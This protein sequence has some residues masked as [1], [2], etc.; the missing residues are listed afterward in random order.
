MLYTVALFRNFVLVYMVE[1][2]TPGMDC[3]Q[4]VRPLDDPKR[5]RAYEVSVLAFRIFTFRVWG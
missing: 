2:R 4:E 3:D 1:E 5:S